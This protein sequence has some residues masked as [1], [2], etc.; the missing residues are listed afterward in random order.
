MSKSFISIKF[1]KR[2]LVI[3]SY[4][5]KFRRLFGEIDYL[6]EENCN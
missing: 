2:K 5:F 1:E 3:K 4:D 6:S